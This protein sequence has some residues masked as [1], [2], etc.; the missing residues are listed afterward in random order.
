MGISEK[1]VDQ[2]Q[3]PEIGIKITGKVSN[4]EA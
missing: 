2:A 1:G 3:L 4:L